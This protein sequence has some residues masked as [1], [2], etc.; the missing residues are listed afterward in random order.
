MAL[1]KSILVMLPVTYSVALSTIME[2]YLL[3]VLKVQKGKRVVREGR[4]AFR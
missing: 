1:F 2:V 4:A 3:T